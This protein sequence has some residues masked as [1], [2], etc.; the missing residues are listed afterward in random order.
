MADSSF[1]PSSTELDSERSNS[2]VPTRQI[3]LVTRGEDAP[4]NSEQ[5]IEISGVENFKRSKQVQG[6]SGR[7]HKI[8]CRSMAQGH[9]QLVTVAG[10]TDIAGV[11]KNKMIP[12]VHLWNK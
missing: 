4:I 8:T 9:N 6:I 10:D 12:I 2:F 3:A 1:L 7:R 11:L 5:D